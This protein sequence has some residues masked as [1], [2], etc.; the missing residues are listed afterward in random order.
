MKRTV[1]KLLDQNRD[2]WSIS[3]EATVFE[4]LEALASHEI[5]AIVVVEDGALIG[6]VSERDYARKVELVDRS[7]RQTPVRQIM[8]PDPKTIA[9]EASVDACMA[10]MTEGRFR[11]LPVMDGDDLVGVVSM[12]DVVRAIV[13]NQ[14]SLIGDLE[15]YI[16]G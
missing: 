7:S 2:L 12:V 6:I 4:A 3:P 10:L 11:H 16:T 5:G 14:A 13:A 8:T 15:R 1:D 9:K